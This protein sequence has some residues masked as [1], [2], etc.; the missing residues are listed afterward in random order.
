M[1]HTTIIEEAPD[2]ICSGLGV[3][4]KL[5]HFGRHGLAILHSQP[6]EAAAIS[7]A[8]RRLQGLVEQYRVQPALIEVSVYEEVMEVILYVD[9]VA[10]PLL[11]VEALAE[12]FLGGL[13]IDLGPGPTR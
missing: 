13:R 12:R 10:V 4:R 5:K 3:R 8:I 1:D 6:L 11:G 2:A 7:K 9:R